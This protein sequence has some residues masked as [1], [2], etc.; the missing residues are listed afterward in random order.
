MGTLWDSFEAAMH[1][2]P[3]LSDV[4]KLTYLRSQLKGSATHVISGFTLTGRNYDS[5]ITLLKDRFGQPHHLVHAHREALLNL[6]SPTDSLSSLQTFYDC[7][8]TCQELNDT[9]KNIESYGDLL[10]TIIRSKLPSKT[11]SIV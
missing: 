4:Q 7:A 6:P 5:S 8:R 1:S 3:T 9:G 2:N 11:W 10:V